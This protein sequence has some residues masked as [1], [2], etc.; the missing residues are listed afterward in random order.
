[1]KKAELLN[2]LKDIDDNVELNFYLIPS[3]SELASES[4]EYDRPLKL[5]GEICTSGLDSDEPY[6]D[7]GLQLEDEVK[8]LKIAIDSESVNIYIDKYEG[9]EEEPIHI[10]YWSECEWE[11]DASMIPSIMRAIELFYTNQK[12]LL[13][14]LGFDEQGKLLK[15]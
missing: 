9:D 7:Y 1:M 15:K 10:A 5:G 4:D 12:L 6:L 2:M 13:E 8:D 11:E 3:N 14:T